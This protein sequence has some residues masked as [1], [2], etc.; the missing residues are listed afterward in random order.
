MLKNKIIL[1]GMLTVF[2]FLVFVSMPSMVNAA[3]DITINSAVINSSNTVLVTL[4]NPGQNIASVDFSKWHI[5]VGGGGATPLSP[6]SAAIT[7]AGT[8]WTLS[9]IHISEPTRP[10]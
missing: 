1:A 2:G 5:D 7:S 4:N 9:L 10:Y 3:A 8:P 6:A